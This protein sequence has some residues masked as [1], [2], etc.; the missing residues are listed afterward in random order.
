[1]RDTSQGGDSSAAELLNG[2]AF[3]HVGVAVAD[4]DK[5]ANFYTTALGFKITSGPFDD[6]IQKVRLLFLADA[7]RQATHIELISPNAEDSP[8][9]TYLK[10]GAGAYHVCYEVSDIQQALA[11]LRARRCLVVSQ[12]VPAVAFGG[13][14]IAWCFTP[15]QQLVELL[16]R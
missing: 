10:Q 4:L 1:M 2:F 15:T 9:N 8:I 13:R 16:E 14:R 5:A 11:L 6:P 12:P 7:G 3:H